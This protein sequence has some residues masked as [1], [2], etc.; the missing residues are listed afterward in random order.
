MKGKY[1]LETY[2]F[3]EMLKEVLKC[4]KQNPFFQDAF[5]QKRHCH[6]FSNNFQ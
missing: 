1:N 2:C 3:T 5:A 4:S 6:Y